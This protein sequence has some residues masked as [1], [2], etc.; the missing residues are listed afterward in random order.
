MATKCKAICMQLLRQSSKVRQYNERKKVDKP[1]PGKSKT[2][3]NNMEIIFTK[4]S[5]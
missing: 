5:K 2:K 4:G 3:E 1:T